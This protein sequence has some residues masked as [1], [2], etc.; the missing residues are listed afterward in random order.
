MNFPL[1]HWC[2]FLVHSDHC[3]HF[4][5]L[6]A[7]VSDSV[8]RGGRHR[9]QPPKT[10]GRISERLV[11]GETSCLARSTRM[12]LAQRWW[13]HQIPEWAGQSFFLT[14]N[15][16]D[17]FVW[18]FWD[19]FSFQRLVYNHALICH[20]HSASLPLEVLL[21]RLR[22]RGHLSLLMSTLSVH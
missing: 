11:F 19:P 17:C 14:R 4:R 2:N 6:S 8:W 15:L 16:G 5:L 9:W 7:Q 10:L 22:L 18:V 21:R 12:L 20:H 13:P 3:Q 1:L